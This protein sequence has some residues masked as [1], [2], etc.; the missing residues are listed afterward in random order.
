MLR[1]YLHMFLYSSSL[2]ATDLGPLQVL[3]VQLS[4]AV[5][6]ESL[7]SLLGCDV[8]LRLSHQLIAHQELPNRRAAEK[9]WVKVH[10]EM[11]RIN[12]LF[13]AFEWSLMDPG[14]FDRQHL[15]QTQR[16]GGGEGERENDNSL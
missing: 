13:R 12:L 14:A 1:F 6:T 8:P 7:S 4:A 3:P 15:Y 9:R 5:F 11:G 2:P 10:V 16:I